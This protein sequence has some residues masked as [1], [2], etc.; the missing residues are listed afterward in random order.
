MGDDVKKNRDN[1]KHHALDAICISFSRD[2]KYNKEKNVDEIEG[3]NP[4]II[5]EAINNLMPYPYANDKTFKGNIKPL[6][7][8]YGKRVKNGNTY[9]T[10]RADITSLEPKEKKINN[11]LDDDIRKDLLNHINNK[12]TNQEWNELLANYTHP[13]KKTHVKNVFK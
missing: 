3:L 13:K 7:S 9:L 10:K 11:I 4:E 6:E 2:Y 1:D 5:K 12:P 8:I